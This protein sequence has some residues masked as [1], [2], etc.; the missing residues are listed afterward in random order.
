MTAVISAAEADPI[1]VMLI[2]EVSPLGPAG[3]SQEIIPS[4]SRNRKPRIRAERNGRSK[5]AGLGGR[6]KQYC[7]TLSRVVFM[8]LLLL[9]QRFYTLEYYRSDPLSRQMTPQP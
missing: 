2:I 8:E 3:P 6:D 7:I 1:M 5:E 4:I 9:N